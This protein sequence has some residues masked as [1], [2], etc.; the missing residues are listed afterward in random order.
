MEVT[1][2]VDFS[3]S[4]TQGDKENRGMGR[5]AVGLSGTFR[6]CDRDEFIDEKRNMRFGFAGVRRHLGLQVSEDIDE[7]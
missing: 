7:P 4:F 3:N 1:R 2:V 5:V 6:L